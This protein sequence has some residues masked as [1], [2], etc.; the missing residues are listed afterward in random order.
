[1]AS[2][3]AGQKNGTKNL[4]WE[5]INTSAEIVFVA[6]PNVSEREFFKAAVQFFEEV[7]DL[8]NLIS[9]HA[10][11]FIFGFQTLYVQEVTAT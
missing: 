1:M 3:R 8:G 9:V 5:V 6:H 7:L 4:H 10:T 2:P 11:S